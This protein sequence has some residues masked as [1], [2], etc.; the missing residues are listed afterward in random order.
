MEEVLCILLLNKNLFSMGLATKKEL[1]ITYYTKN[2]CLLTTQ[3]SQ[4]GGNLDWSEVK[5]AL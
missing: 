5:K 2:N 1:A 4:G 3:R